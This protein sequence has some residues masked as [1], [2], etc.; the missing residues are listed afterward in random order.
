MRVHG[1]FPSYF[2]QLLYPPIVWKRINSHISGCEKL[3]ISIIKLT[4]MVNLDKGTCFHYN[5]VTITLND[6][7]KE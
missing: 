6:D 5:T 7:E 1:Q 2:T 4:D 3:K